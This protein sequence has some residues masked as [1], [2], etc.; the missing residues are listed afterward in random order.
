[1][2]YNRFVFSPNKRNGLSCLAIIDFVWWK[3]NQSKVLDWIQL[4]KL[5]AI[6]DDRDMMIE[7]G[8][9]ADIDWFIMT[10]EKHG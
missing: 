5:N 7:F 8:N 2:T 4:V 1:M 3:Y 9:A 10:W 6:Y